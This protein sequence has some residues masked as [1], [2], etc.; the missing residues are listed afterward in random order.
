LEHENI[1]KIKEFFIDENNLNIFYIVMEFCDTKFRE[2]DI[3]TDK[4]LRDLMLQFFKGLKYVKK[5]FLIFYRFM[6]KVSYTKILK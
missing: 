5:I 6:K 1:V 2:Y 3:K 4:E